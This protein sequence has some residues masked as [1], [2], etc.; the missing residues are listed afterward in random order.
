MTLLDEN[1][2]PPI[3]VSSLY[4]KSVPE[5]KQ[6]GYS[7]FTVDV[8][9]PDQTGSLQLSLTGE[10]SEEFTIVQDGKIYQTESNKMKDEI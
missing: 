10:G 9:D 8:Y 7:V 5:N 2:T 4:S 6:P 1:D 3:F